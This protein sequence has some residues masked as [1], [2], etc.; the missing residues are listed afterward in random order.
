M[1]A[2]FCRCFSILWMPNP[3]LAQTRCLPSPSTNHPAA[4]RCVA[5]LREILDW[6]A[7][8]PLLRQL[9][10][11]QRV[12]AVGHSRGGKLSTLLGLADP[13]V[14]A[15]FLIDP[16]DVT[17]RRCGRCARIAL[18]VLVLQAGR[19]AGGEEPCPEGRLPPQPEEHPPIAPMCPPPRP[20]VCASG[21]RLPLGLRGP[22]GAGAPGP[23]AAAGGGGIRAGRR[24][25]AC[26]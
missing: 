17:V 24:L 7:A 19:Q 3:L 15:L 25:R 11:T 16:V 22:G 21:P 18:L 14:R 5:L 4:R 20:G 2:G 8:D 13:R 10:D 6:C 26:R 9:A 23:L 12:L 1:A